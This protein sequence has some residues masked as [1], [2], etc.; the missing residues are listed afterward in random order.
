[1][2]QTANNFFG[3]LNI[4]KPSGITSHDVVA[5]VRRLS[6]IK[7]VGHTGTL[8]PLATGV[9]LVAL[10]KV[11]RLVRF[12]DNWRKTY[13]AEITLGEISDT[14]DVEGKITAVEVEKEPSRE[15][16]DT[17]VNEQRGEL[18]QVPPKY[19]AIK[20]RGK[21][22]YEYARAGEK[23][24]APARQVTVYDLKIIDYNYPQIKIAVECSA[25][26]YIR[27]IA[28]D[29]GEALGTGGYLS[30]LRRTAIGKFEI[31]GGVALED[32]NAENLHNNIQPAEKLLA[33]LPKIVVDNT[34]VVKLVQGR[35]VSLAGV[36][37]SSGE[38]AMFG[39]DNFLIGIGRYESDSSTLSPTVVV[40]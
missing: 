21:K 7:R 18:K 31:S 39:P 38:V 10:G 28:R 3:V 11:T 4:D 36:K 24:E 20:V 2:E 27:S 13:E 16:V 19:A 23:V 6:G 14:D 25:G 33:K 5:Q 32:L 15:E 29:M 30:S 12:T 26:T 35:A 34:N 9:L 1:M 17:A 37:H 8:D 40:A 22:L